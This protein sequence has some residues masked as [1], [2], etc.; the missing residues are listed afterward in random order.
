M[1]PVR[2]AMC[3]HVYDVFDASR[4]M[5]AWA[6]V[7]ALLVLGAFLV[8]PTGPAPSVSYP[9]PP[10]VF[11][12]TSASFAEAGDNVTVEVRT[13]LGANLTD[14]D[15]GPVVQASGVGTTLPVEGLTHIG[16]GAYGAYLVLPANG[17][18]GTMNESY[19]EVSATATLGSVRTSGYAYVDWVTPGPFLRFFSNIRM[20]GELEDMHLRAEVYNDTVPVDADPGSVSFYLFSLLGAGAAFAPVR[21]GVGVYEADA[22]VRIG[23]GTIGVGAN[24][25]YRGIRLSR[26]LSTV[27]WMDSAQSP[28]LRPPTYQAWYHTISANETLVHGDLWVAD[29]WGRPA[30]GV[31]VNLTLRWTRSF[32]FTGTTNASGAFPLDVPLATGHASIRG[33]VGGSSSMAVAVGG[34]FPAAACSASPSAPIILTSVDP[35]ILTDGSLRDY[36]Q[37]GAFV[38]RTYHA[39]NDS[40]PSLAPLANTPFIYHLVGASSGT[41]YGSGHGVTDAGGNAS[42]QFRVPAET[43]GLWFY[44]TGLP[45]SIAISYSVASALMGLQVSALQLG[46][47]TDVEASFEGRGVMYADSGRL[48]PFG[49]I[50]L[51][52]SSDGRWDDWSDVD[53]CPTS[54]LGGTVGGVNATFHLPSFL[55]S[56]GKYLVHAW[57]RGDS[58]FPEQYALLSPGE[59]VSIPVVGPGTGGPELEPILLLITLGAVVAAIAVVGV[60]WVLRRRRRGSP[61]PPPP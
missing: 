16:T 17:P 50:Q 35:P 40:S 53:H 13:Y 31:P 60:L 22:T 37:P 42:L 2:G 61:P 20:V 14:P 52:S 25:T 44:Y 45:G 28:E 11:V 12:S 10:R 1:G 39:L 55:P 38:L 56:S 4:L 41:V 26:A 43:F 48:A 51:L 19:V 8:P 7:A 3:R 57:A 9:N 32:T 24:A 59:S 46:G 58:V 5:R 34:A 54:F 21:T 36:L 27:G 23:N 47:P 15:A 6:A 18:S 29:A 30:A 33:T 49:S